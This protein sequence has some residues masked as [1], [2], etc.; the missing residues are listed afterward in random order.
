MMFSELKDTLHGQHLAKICSVA[1]M[2]E[3]QEGSCPQPRREGA[4][5]SP[6]MGLESEWKEHVPSVLCSFCILCSQVNIRQCFFLV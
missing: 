4:V 2:C 3:E 5:A 6:W 1:W